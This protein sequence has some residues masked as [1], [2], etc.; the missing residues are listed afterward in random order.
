MKHIDV[1]SIGETLIQQLLAVN[2]WPRISLSNDPLVYHPYAYRYQARQERLL[3]G[4]RHSRQSVTPPT[5]T[6]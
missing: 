1:L 2:Y 3:T 6:G 5:L 4:S